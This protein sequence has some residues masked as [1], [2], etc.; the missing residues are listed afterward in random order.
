MGTAYAI[1]HFLNA[2]NW[3]ETTRE[4]KITPIPGQITVREFDYK[5][6]NEVIYQENGVTIRSMPVMGLSVS[7]SSM[8]DSR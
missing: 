1:D 5:G 6:V 2:N 8:R 4:F 7:F 3:D